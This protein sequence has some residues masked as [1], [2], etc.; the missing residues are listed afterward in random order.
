MALIVQDDTG[1]VSGANAYISLVEFKTYHDTRGNNYLAFTDTEIENAIIRSSDYVDIR[2]DFIGSKLNARDQIT[3]WPRSSALDRDGWYV[4]G[5]PLEIK[6][7]IAEYAFR[8]LSSPLIP[9]P[10]TD[11]TGREVESTEIKAGP[12]TK[13]VSYIG[14]GQNT[15]K[16]FPKADRILANLLEP[17][18]MIARG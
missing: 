2:F 11:K 6:D 12:I 10:V 1:A 9:D 16:P 15:F 5:I 4:T 3:Q 13:K 18:G 14:R 17:A 8:A 7:A